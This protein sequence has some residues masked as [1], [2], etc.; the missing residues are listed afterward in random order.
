MVGSSVLN[1]NNLKEIATMGNFHVLEH[2]KDLSVSAGS[3]IN[4]YFASKMNV[5]KMTKIC[6][7]QILKQLM[8]LLK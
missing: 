2:E 3:A 6:V 7:K 4:Y 5:R 1:N 8:K